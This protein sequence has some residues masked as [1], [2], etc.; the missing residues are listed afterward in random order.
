MTVHLSELLL[1][2]SKRLHFRINP[3][4]ATEGKSRF[5]HGSLVG[6]QKHDHFFLINYGCNGVRLSSKINLTA[7]RIH[8]T[9][10][11]P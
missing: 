2:K 10:Q 6:R 11:G 5:L 7:R 3:L 9:E 4:S 1:L 8:R